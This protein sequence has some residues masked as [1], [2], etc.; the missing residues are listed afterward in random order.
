[1]RHQKIFKLCMGLCLLLAG[2][3]HVDAKVTLPAI[4]SDNMIIQQKSTLLLHGTAQKESI[5]TISPS[6]SRKSFTTHADGNGHWE[7]QVTTPKAG[8]PYRITF[9]DG[10]ITM[11][12]NVVVGEVW[13][14]SGQSNM[15]MPV[16]GWGKV[17]NYEQEIKEANYPDIRFFQVK[18][19][20]SL[21]PLDE[22]VPNMDGWQ[23][24][25]P[26]TVP[27]FS[28]L[29][30]FYARQLHKNLKVPIGVIDCTWGGT[31]AE[32][33][34][35]PSALQD[36]VGYESL[37]QQLQAIGYDAE[38]VM[39]LHNRLSIEWK[40]KASNIDLGYREEWH[41][42][43]CENIDWD[44][45]TLPNYWEHQGLKDFDGV[46][47]FRRQIDIP[48]TCQGYELKLNCGTIDDEDAVYW[49]GELI[50][51]GSGYNVH[52][53]Y[54]VPAEKVRIGKNILTIRV[55]DTGGE[56]GIAGNPTD[57]N[58]CCGDKFMV[59]LAGKWQYRIG[60]SFASLPQPPIWPG[61]SS[62]PGVLFNAMV[63]PWLQFPIKGVIWYQGCAN[64]GRHEQYECLFQ[65]L[66]H[67]WR[68]QFNQPEMPFYF[69]QLANFQERVP[70]Q[71]DSQWAALREAQAKA[72]SIDG[73]GMVCNIDLGEAYDIHPKNKQAVAHRLASLSLANTYSKKLPATAP[74]YR[75]YS[76][77]G[78]KVY[79]D[80]D[81]PRH[82]EGLSANTE[83]KGFIIAGT[84]R[85][86]HPATAYVENGR[87]VVSSPAVSHPIAVRYAWADNPECNLSTPSG[88]MVAPFRTDDWDLY[89]RMNK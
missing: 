11:L 21:L 62:Y 46:V 26:Q 47:W 6:W 70:L 82:G 24:C 67:D 74:V 73:T 39:E 52:R 49:N 4:Y 77:K 8:G 59:P 71:P 86:F 64:V 9:D 88:L 33:W 35:S 76:V 81:T 69:V 78:N 13:F 15:E 55:F 18:K 53:S 80:F 68:Q 12:D 28:S 79:I 27:E 32:A 72:L 22:V 50:A 65:R 37:I 29:A 63:H 44:T 45:M 3:S 75:S 57:M 20:T 58:L 19:T 87:V 41:L 48:E 2:V 66:I 84:D 5:V 85:R 51:T 1:M 38:K 23:E 40:Q 7:I 36:V 16:A 34:T 89:G 61:S 31:P 30:Y 83:V 14:C 17:L 43:D 42:L 60:C 10:D 25:S 56:G 54:T